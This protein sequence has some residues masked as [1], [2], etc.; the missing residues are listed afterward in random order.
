VLASIHE[1]VILRREVPRLRHM[2]DVPLTRAVVDLSGLCLTQRLKRVQRNL[3]EGMHP[4][5]DPDALLRKIRKIEGWRP[6]RRWQEHYNA[7]CAYA[8]PLLDTDAP[9]EPETAHLLTIAAVARLERAIECA[10]SGFVASRRDWLLSDDPDLD[11]LRAA[12]EFKHFE[13]IYF[14]S[15][16]SAKK[17]PSGLHKWELSRYTLDLLSGTATRFGGCW[18]ARKAGLQGEVE[19]PVLTDWC[20]VE[21]QA[22]SRVLEVTRNHQ[23]WRARVKL[24]EFARSLAMRTDFD[25]PK[26]RFP[27]FAE[28]EE[29]IADRVEEWVRENDDRFEALAEAIEAG[30]REALKSPLLADLQLR[31]L[32]LGRLDGRGTTLSQADAAELCEAHATVWQAFGR[33]VSDS[34]GDPEQVL[35]AVESLIG[36]WNAIKAVL[37]TGV[38]TQAPPPVA[39]GTAVSNL[40]PPV[41]ASVSA[42]VPARPSRYEPLR[43]WRHRRTAG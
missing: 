34:D 20:D 40:A 15:S 14:P 1:L 26:V 13:A 11:G 32:E 17:R 29:P 24:I 18:R 30:Q 38:A 9:P 4:D 28:L 36:R 7:A 31:R 19:I 2:K 5:S 37:E 10:D 3:S 42:V 25:A 43:K 16:L 23:H 33:C 22:W 35:D 6:F 12:E 39:V 41:S 21:M 8:I 27:Q